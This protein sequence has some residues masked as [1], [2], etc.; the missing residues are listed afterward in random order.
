MWI[1]EIDFPTGMKD[2]VATI[3]NDISNRD[4]TFIWSIS[5][6]RNKSILKVKS[7]SKATAWKR[8]CWLSNRVEPLKDFLGFKIRWVNE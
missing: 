2:E 6:S 5:Y 3:M 4:Q 8:F 1:T 7:D